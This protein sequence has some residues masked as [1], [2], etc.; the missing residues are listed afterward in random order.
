MVQRHRAVVVVDRDQTL[1]EPALGDGDRRPA[2]AFEG[3]GVDGLARNALHG[4]DGVGANAL[5]G[6]RVQSAE[7]AIAGI[8]QRRPVLG[9]AAVGHG[10]HFGSARHYHVGHAGHDGRRRQVHRGNAGTAESVEGDAARAHV[11]PRVQ[12][13]HA[14]QVAGR[15]SALR[16]GAPDHVVDLGGINA[17]ALG[18]GPQHRRAQAL[19][20]EMRQRALAEFSHAAGRA[21]GVDDPGFGHGGVSLSDGRGGRPFR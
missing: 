10:H 2:L 6:L 9:T 17:V 14:A 18:Q 11:V 5:V 7:M 16:T 20:V 19:R 3:Q 4:R 15:R 8:H 12:R 13:R 1:G 21:A